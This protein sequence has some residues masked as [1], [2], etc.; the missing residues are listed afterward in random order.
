MPRTNPLKRLEK[1][2]SRG[3]IYVRYA[4]SMA[5]VAGFSVIL[6]Y[7][8]RHLVGRGKTLPSAIHAALDQ[9]EAKR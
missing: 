9:A 1:W 5:T 2:L 7:G 8:D 6:E 3:Y 4:N